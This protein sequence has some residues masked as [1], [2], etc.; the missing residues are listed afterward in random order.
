MSNLRVRDLMT[1]DVQVVHP[2]DPI[3]AVKEL[4]ADKYIRHVPVVDDNGQ[5]VGLVT[6]RDLLRQAG[7]LDL[8]VPLSV[9]QE[10]SSTVKV[11]EIMNWQVD[12]VDANEDVVNAAAIMLESKYGCLPVLEQGELAGIL[13]EADFVRYVAETASGESAA[14]SESRPAER[15]GR[16]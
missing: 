6:E 4:M 11:R 13:T 10:V 7:G 9:S 2:D 14:R 12:T 5:L 1:P 15:K 16:S 3:A 8:D